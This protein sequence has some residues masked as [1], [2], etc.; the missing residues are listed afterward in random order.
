MGANE[1]CPGTDPLLFTSVL[2]LFETQNEEE[3]VRH[4]E[5]G[6]RCQNDCDAEKC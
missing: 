3:G 5:K 6:L 1:G 4:E 2:L